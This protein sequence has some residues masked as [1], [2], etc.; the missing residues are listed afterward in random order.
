MRRLPVAWMASGL[1]VLGLCSTVAVARRAPADPGIGSNTVEIL[2]YQA[3]DHRYL[4]IPDGDPLPV[5]FEQPGFDDS[6]FA[7]GSAAFG[8]PAGACAL[9]ATVAT[10]WPLETTLLVRRIVSLPA[11]AA[12]VR[13]MAAVDNDIVV[14]PV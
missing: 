10:E 2:P 6:G 13:V 9:Q 7:I 14:V 1:F 8:S 11:G 3:G 5:D 4:T 12:N